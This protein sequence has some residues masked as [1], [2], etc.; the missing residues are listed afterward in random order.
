MKLKRIYLTIYSHLT[1]KLTFK[2]ENNGILYE[3]KIPTKV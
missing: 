2:S 1:I 3:P